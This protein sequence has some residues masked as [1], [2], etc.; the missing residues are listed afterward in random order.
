MVSLRPRHMIWRMLGGMVLAVLLP[1]AQAGAPPAQEPPDQVVVQLADATMAAIVDAGSVETAAV[2][3]VAE[4]V[5]GAFALPT[6]ARFTL[7][8]YWQGTTE[9]EQSAY[10]DAF[11]RHIAATTIRRF[12]DFQQDPL[13]VLGS[14][15]VGDTD[16]LLGTLATR[17]DGT[18]SRLLWRLRPTDSGWRIVD[19]VL[20]GVS[21]GVTSRDEFAAFLGRHDGE[22]TAL[23]EAL[24]SGGL[25]G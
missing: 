11:G 25:G 10:E 8:D 9:S 22:V 1:V 14:R 13:Q 15:P 5:R 19:I 21:L 24:S 2:D 23:I 6:L 3:D 7:G 4:L 12:R 16:T 20:D 18:T 17:R